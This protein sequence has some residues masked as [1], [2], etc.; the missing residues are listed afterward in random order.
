M[1]LLSQVLSN[2]LAAMPRGTSHDLTGLLLTSG[3]AVILRVDDGGEWRLDLRGSYH[4]L[5]SR[6]VRVRGVRSDFDLI[7]VDRI[8]PV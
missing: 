8:E 3:R 4:R 2:I 7:G 1:P 6:R 5:L